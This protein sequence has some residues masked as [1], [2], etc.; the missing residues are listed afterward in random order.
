M[1]I[2]LGP[3]RDAAPSLPLC[4][5]LGVCLAQRGTQSSPGVEGAGGLLFAGLS[6]VMGG[7]QGAPTLPGPLG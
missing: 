2:G 4:P 7:G 1:G 6:I 5:W 3:G